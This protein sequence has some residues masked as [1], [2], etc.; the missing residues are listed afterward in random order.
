VCVCVFLVLFKLSVKTGVLFVLLESL[1]DCKYDGMEMLLEI[2]KFLPLSTTAVTDFWLLIVD[3][4][5]YLEPEPVNI[6][7][8]YY[9]GKLDSVGHVTCMFMLCRVSCILVNVAIN[10]LSSLLE[11]KLELMLIVNVVGCN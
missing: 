4:C 3:I 6:E 1:H 2:A 10:P 11:T 9:F 8:L 5:Q 7:K